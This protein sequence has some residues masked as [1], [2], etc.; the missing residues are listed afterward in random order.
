[1]LEDYW[2]PRREGGRGTEVS[3]L[4]AGQNLGELE[5]IKYFQK[6]LY[7]SLHVPASR[8]EQDTAGGFQLGRGA[9]INRDE[10]KFTKFV[11]R[12][13]NRFN[14]L[15]NDLLKTQLILKG[16]ITSLDWEMFKEHINYDY[17]RDAHFAE[18]KESE[19]MRDRL[20]TL[21]QAEQYMGKFYSEEWCRKNILHQT[22]EEIEL[23]N[24][25][26]NTEN[27]QK[28]ENGDGEELDEL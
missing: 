4:P 18:L 6:K 28:K 20:E 7:K 27:D 12:L 16:I 24:E 5:D 15:F 22:S 21:S 23:N 13:R 3:T 11:N 10:L 9:E 8:I 2:L 17:I 14:H 19:L 26:I 1:M 25:Q